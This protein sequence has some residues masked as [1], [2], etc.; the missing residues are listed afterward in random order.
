MNYELQNK[1]IHPLIPSQFPEFYNE[2]GQVFISFVTEYYKW[3]ESIQPAVNTSIK[4]KGTVSVRAQSNE[5]IG[6]NTSFG[7]HFKSGDRIAIYTNDSNYNIFTIDKVSNNTLLTLVAP[8]PDI[9]VSNSIYR[10]V[11]D[12]KNPLYRSRRLLDN[13]DIDIAEDEFVLL[14]KEK[15]L[16]DIHFDTIIDIRKFIKYSLD[17][18]RSKGTGRAIDLLYK[19]VFGVPAKVYYPKKDIFTTSSSNWYIPR[20]IE[21][22]LNDNNKLF[23]NKTITGLFSGATAFVDAIVRKTVKGKLLD[24]A[25][26]SSINGSFET[27]EKIIGANLHVNDCPVM[28]GSLNYIRIP[29]GAGGSEFTVGDD[30]EVL[31][32]S[33][34]GAK[35]RVTEITN[36]PGR[37]TFSLIDGGYGYSSNSIVLISDQ[38]LTINNIT[39]SDVGDE[40]PLFDTITQPLA[41]LNYLNANGSFEVGQSIFTYHANNDLKGEGKILRINLSGLDSGIILASITSG[42]LDSD[43]I[44]TDSNTV[45]ANLNVL[46]GFSDV[47]TSA[48]VMG[49][50]SNATLYTDTTNGSFVI[51]ERIEQNETGARGVITNITIPN[52]SGLNEIY[53][54]NFFGRF[55][56]NSQI[57]GLNSGATANVNSLSLNVGVVDI[58]GY[59]FVSINGNRTNF[60][61]IDL[62]G[63]ITDISQGSDG[64]FQLNDFIHTETVNLNTDFLRDYV[65]VGLSHDPLGFPNAPSANSTNLPIAQILNYIDKEIGSINSI[66]PISFGSGYNKIPVVLVYDNDMIEYGVFN[67][68]DTQILYLTN[69]SNIYKEGELV[70]QVDSGARGVV[71]SQNS[72]SITIRRMRYYNHNQF[73]ETSN[74]ATLLISTQ[75][76]AVSNIDFIEISP[77]SDRQGKNA[78]FQI[79][80]R[81]G[82]GVI[83]EVQVLDSG[84]GYNNYNQLT[85]MNGNNVAFGFG[86][87]Q[88]SGT[89]SGYFKNHNGFLSSNKRIF[90]GLYYSFHSYDVKSSVINSHKRNLKKIIHT[91][92]TKYYDS[93]E[94]DSLNVIDLQG[95]TKIEIT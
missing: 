56:S 35:A 10:T 33:G 94:Y 65:D 72:T 95:H 24:V 79:D 45:S 84:Y 36:D 63:Q 8:L 5:V 15:Y 64:L 18:Y 6:L 50:Y 62:S 69:V 17:L 71:K 22:S 34:V 54:N 31:S 41:N 19:S 66:I 75:S 13:R 55:I 27:N 58:N 20:Y 32:S 59:G 85:L 7:S 43:A 4:T 78:K 49:Y 81:T 42:N 76:G 91:A 51:G 40:Y 9:S 28:I 70:I 60:S 12:Q 3:L 87:L 82:N 53:I 74:S 21:L 44:Y 92:G 26:I 16:K 39:L 86:E 61:N 48:N 25:Y 89:G 93:L 90:D 52:E 1:A 29:E 67:K 57:T 80:L 14:F 11:I 83:K 73:V 23:H 47:S 30:L 37:L 38:V 77:E 68:E 2:D 88:T 46:D